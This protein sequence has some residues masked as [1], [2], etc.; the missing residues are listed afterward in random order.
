[1]ISFC[2]YVINIYF[3]ANIKK[4]YCIFQEGRGHWTVNNTG[5]Q[6]KHVHPI[7]STVDL[8][9]LET[10]IFYLLPKG[11]AGYWIHNIRLIYNAGYPVSIRI[12]GQRSISGKWLDNRIS[13]IR[14]VLMSDIWPDIRPIRVS[15]PTLYANSVCTFP[16]IIFTW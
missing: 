9:N 3:M 14:I 13:G 1:M 10:F 6:S 7:N 8:T 5:N 2:L 15:G 16:T 4:N 11:W 12:S